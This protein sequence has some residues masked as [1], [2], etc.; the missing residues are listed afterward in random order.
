[1]SETQSYKKAML[2]QAL[3]YIGCAVGCLFVVAFDYF[4][5]G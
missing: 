5:R 1:M 2:I 4:A 3:P